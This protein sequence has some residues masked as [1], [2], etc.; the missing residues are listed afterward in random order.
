MLA[1]NEAV[2][3]FFQDLELPSVY[4]YHGEPD[5]EKL[6]PSRPSARSRLRA[7]RTGSSPRRAERAP[8]AAGRPPRAAGAQP[9]AAA[10]DDA[11]GLLV[12]ERGPLRAGGRA[13]PALHLAHPALSGSPGAP[14]AEG[15]WGGA[16]QA[17][18]RRSWTRETERLEA[19][20]PRAP[21]A[22][23]RRCRWSARSSS[24]YSVLLMKDRVGEEFAATVAWRHRLRLLRG[25]GEP[26][27]RGGL[28]KGESVGLDFE[29]ESG[30]STRSFSARTGGESRRREADRPADLGQSRAAA[31]RLR[32]AALRGGGGAGGAPRGAR[33]ECRSREDRP[34]GLEAKL[35][36]SR[37][38]RARRRRPGTTQQPR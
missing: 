9:A 26:E 28:V 13:L 7:L 6:G 34:R 30:S 11:G 29:F 33:R 14:A 32:G 27:H 8:R 37:R 23:A 12:G 18:R 10:L 5:E 25:A 3:K 19:W 21:S 1:A 22:S 2:A 24:F 4:R 38:R 31:A 20:P 35:A 17:Q 36:K 16:A 15:A